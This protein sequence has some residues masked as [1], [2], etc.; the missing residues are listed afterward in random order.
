M[1]PG[2]SPCG[3]CQYG[4]AHIG[5]QST[6]E[7]AKQM[8]IHNKIHNNV[9]YSIQTRKLGIPIPKHMHTNAKKERKKERKN[10]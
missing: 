10:T 6:K 8:Q 7:T 4:L 2:P 3:L 5:E 1:N 9:T